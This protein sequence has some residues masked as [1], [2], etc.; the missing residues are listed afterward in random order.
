MFRLS[1]RRGDVST[2]TA[3]YGPP[4]DGDRQRK[5]RGLMEP[6]PEAQGPSLYAVLMTI[7]FVLAIV[8]AAVSF[9][10]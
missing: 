6:D 3:P 4:L 2:P 7:A 10:P 5:Q 9:A 8:V 1:P